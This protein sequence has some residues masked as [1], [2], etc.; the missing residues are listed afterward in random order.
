MGVESFFLSRLMNIGGMKFRP[1]AL[2]DI[3][4]GLMPK[5]SVYVSY[6]VEVS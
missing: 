3:G 1:Q 4:G 6:N 2:I 5:L